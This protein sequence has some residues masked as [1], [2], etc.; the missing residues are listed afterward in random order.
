MVLA[1]DKG[2]AYF[3]RIRIAGNGLLFA[4]DALSGAITLLSILAA[5]RC[6]AVNLHQ[7]SKMNIF[8]K[9]AFN[10]DCIGFQAIGGYLHAV[11]HAGF[12]VVHKLDSRL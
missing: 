10:R 8:S 6:I 5:F 11:R 12:Q 3:L 9:N 1:L 7:L 4:A 2:S